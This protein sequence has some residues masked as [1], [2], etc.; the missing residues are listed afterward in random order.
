MAV[1][2]ARNTAQVATGLPQEQTRH[3]SRLEQ[4]QAKL[5]WIMLLPTLLALA[6]VAFYPLISTFFYSLTNAR[7]AS[8]RPTRFIGLQN[9]QDLLSDTDF[10]HSIGTTVRFTL[11]TVVFEFL[12]GMIVALVIN[13]N[14]KGRGAMRAIML[15]PWAI[16]TA[17]STQMWKWM[18]NQVYGVFNDLLV[19]R[20]HFLNSPVA[21]VAQANTSLPAICAVDIWKT[22]PFVALLLLAGLQVV[23]SEVYEAA[24][25]DGASAV[26]QFFAITLPLLRP[27]IVVTLIFRTLDALRVF[28]VIYVMFGGRA[29]TQS[30]VI[31]NQRT[32]TEFSQLGYGSAVSVAVF[33]IIGVF[34]VI[35]ATVLKVDQQS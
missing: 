23:P 26:R 24:R 32:I 1:N 16:P 11:I 17:V 14:F 20:T 6:L 18:Y 25:V 8:N 34:V 28:D 35:Y 29:D 3:R 33:L 13:S 31:Y 10:V 4:S 7:L 2:A 19:T 12:L 15:V 27:A 9:F 5:A 22:T 30:M 21:W